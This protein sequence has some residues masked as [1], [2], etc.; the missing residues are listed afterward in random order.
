[1]QHGVRGVAAVSVAMVLLMAPHR[2]PAVEVG[3]DGGVEY[4]KQ[5]RFTQLALSTPLG[6]WSPLPALRITR[7]TS[8]TG[9]VETSVSL[10]LQRS[11]GE[12]D[13]LVALGVSHVFI[14][15]ARGTAVRRYV[16][17]GGLL[18]ATQYSAWPG[19]QTGAGLVRPLSDHAN[20][21][22]ELLYAR[23]GHRLRV[24]ALRAGL[25]VR[26]P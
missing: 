3:V 8:P 10:D 22:L 6:A 20:A 21:R 16:R 5:G 18:T 19:V 25:S 7:D 14:S 15:R 9:Q 4:Q 13:L 26:L 17:V 11:R 1:M 2:A 23:P 12:T 24:V